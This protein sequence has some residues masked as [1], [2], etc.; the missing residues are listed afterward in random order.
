MMMLRGEQWQHSN[1]IGPP[2]I[3]RVRHLNPQA[4]GGNITVAEGLPT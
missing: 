3:S 1:V 4:G 2:R